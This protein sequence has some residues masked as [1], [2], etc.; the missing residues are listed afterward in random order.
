VVEEMASFPN[1]D[2]DD[3]VDSSSQALLRFR[4]GGFIRLESDEKD[5]TFIVLSNIDVAPSAA[6]MAA[7]HH[8]LNGKSVDLPYI[9]K[10]IRMDSTTLEKFTGKY[11]SNFEFTIERVG[12]KIV[13]K[14]ANGKAFELTP[15]SDIKFFYSDGADRQ[16]EFE[17][18]T[19]NKV[20]KAWFINYGV[21][22]SFDRIN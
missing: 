3:L 19:T 2:N 21:R 17:L 16:I 7:A 5:Q 22:T 1:G 4:Q 18:D 13:R 10:A 20:S 11:K 14:D 6:L 15:E 9:H 12:E 8:L